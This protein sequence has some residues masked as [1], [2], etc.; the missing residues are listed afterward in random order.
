MVTAGPGHAMLAISRNLPEKVI[1]ALSEKEADKRMRFVE[2]LRNRLA[3]TGADVDLYTY[4]R[5]RQHMGLVFDEDTPLS[6]AFRLV[7]AASLSG[8]GFS[9][10][11][12]HAGSDNHCTIPLPFREGD[13]PPCV[14]AR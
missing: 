7:P 8:L 12:I 5:A 6:E 9:D 13:P 14:S 3:R 2:T 1:H 4:G 11:P 10:L